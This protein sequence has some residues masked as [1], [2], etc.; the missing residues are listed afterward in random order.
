MQIFIANRNYVTWPKKMAEQLAGQGHEITFIDNGSTYIPLLDYYKTCDFKIIRLHN[1]GGHAAWAANIVTDLDE[2]FV[3]SDPDYDLSMV[4][5]D[6]DEVL[7]EGLRQFPGVN[8]F[9][10]SW[11][12]SQVPQENPAY[13]M[14]EMYKYSEQNPRYPRL[15]GTWEHA[16]NDSSFALQRPHSEDG[17]TGIRKA[18]PYTGIH[19]PWHITLEPAKD[20]TKRYYLWDDEIAYYF[21]TCEHSSCTWGRMVYHDVINKYLK[22]H[23]K[24][25][26]WILKEYGLPK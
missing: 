26:E 19:M 13:E 2:P 16:A 20:P 12:E 23:N 1:A 3:C 25:A 15:A 4:P 22:L 24:T 18:Y 6:W 11:G 17:I 5:S 9:G 14:D 21:L 8:K 7:L 10:L